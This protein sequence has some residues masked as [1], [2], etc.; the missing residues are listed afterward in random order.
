MAPP[1][2][3][4]ADILIY[5]L[6]RDERL[7]WPIAHV[8]LCGA[9]VEGDP[10]RISPRSSEWENRQAPCLADMTLIAWRSVQSFRVTYKRVTDVQMGIWNCYNSI[11]GSAKPCYTAQR[12][13]KNGRLSRRPPSAWRTLGTVYAVFISGLGGQFEII[14]LPSR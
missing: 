6:R 7:S 2:T 4:V 14:A 10:T 9:R 11:H 1:L 13:W 12:W 3:D 8:G 5:R